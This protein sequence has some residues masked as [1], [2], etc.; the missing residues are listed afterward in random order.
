MQPKII[1]D[2]TW[3]SNKQYNTCVTA[4]PDNTSE[5]VPNKTTEISLKSKPRTCTYQVSNGKV[6]H[7]RIY[8]ATA[9]TKL[10]LRVAVNGASKSMRGELPLSNLNLTNGDFGDDAGMFV[11][12]RDYCFVGK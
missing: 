12:N 7:E 9:K 10:C 4:H 5:K 3:V 1:Y 2:E 8:P 11:D 6:V